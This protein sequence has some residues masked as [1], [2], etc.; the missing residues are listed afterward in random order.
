MRALL[1]GIVLLGFAAA[2]ASGCGVVA[3]KTSKLVPALPGSA[4][5]LAGTLAKGGF[6]FQA[7]I[8]ITAVGTEIAKKLETEQMAPDVAAKMQ[9]MMARM[10][11]LLADQKVDE[12]RAVEEDALHLLGYYKTYFRCGFGVA[13]WMKRAAPVTAPRPRS[14]SST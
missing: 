14:A 7:V 4:A 3:I 10:T 6:H 5:D 8:G 9:D 2:P 12:A 1:A 11:A 13:V